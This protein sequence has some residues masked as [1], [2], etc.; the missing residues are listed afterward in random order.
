MKLYEFQSKNIL[1]MYGIYVPRGKAISSGNDASKVFREIGCNRCVLKAQVLAGGRGKGGGIQFINTPEEAQ[2]CAA[3][4][5]GSYLTTHQTGQT[6][7]KVNYL[8]VEEA[9]SIQREL[10]LAITIDRALCTPIL[11]VS[12]EGGVEIEEIAKKTPDKIVKEPIDVFLGILSFQLRCIASRLDISGALSIKFN[13]LI[14]NLF[15]VFVKNDCSLV[16][17]NPLVV[18]GDEELCAL[19]AKIDVDDNALYRHPEFQEFIQTQDLSPPEALARKYK[20]S[21][22]SLDGNIGCL[23]NGAGLAMATMDIIK[24]HGG[25]PANFLDVG[26][27]ASL[28]QVTQAFKIILSDSKVKA[29]LINIF[30]GIMKCDIIASGIIQAVKEVGIHI[31]LVVRLEGTNVDR[32]K[33]ILH[34]S[35]LPILSAKDMKE[36]AS[37]VV[38]VS[39]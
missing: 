38:K 37:L 14:T 27:D 31:P 36:A 4:M 20:L 33:K 2:A 12:S 11:I 23:V 18:T 30:G 28:E 3:G 9:L 32:A 10:Y 17:I 22:I 1:K 35:G 29:I 34:D 21:Y 24:F 5:L 8:L 19:D 26:G 6:G 16:E 25:E 39:R 15:H 7:I 13:N